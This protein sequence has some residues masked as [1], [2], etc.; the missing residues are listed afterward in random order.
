V[1]LALPFVNVDAVCLGWVI[2][3][4]ASPETDSVVLLLR[5]AVQGLGGDDEVI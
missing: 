2:D 1:A 4:E 3:T 5:Y